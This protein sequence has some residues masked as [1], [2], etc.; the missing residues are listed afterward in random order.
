MKYIKSFNEAKSKTPNVKKI[1]KFLNRLGITEYTINP[2]GTVDL[3]N[4]IDLESTSDDFISFFKKLPI[5]FGHIEGDFTFEK[6]YELTTMEGFPK[7]CENFYFKSFSP[8]IKNL[9]G[10]P[11]HVSGHYTVSSYGEIT[12]LEGGPNYVGG[13]FDLSENPVTSLKGCPNQIEGDF[14]GD[15][16]R[17][18]SLE[19]CTQNIG[20]DLMLTQTLLTSLIGFPRTVTIVSISTQE[21]GLWDPTGIRDSECEMLY[22]EGEPL[23]ELIDLFNPIRD[24]YRYES[25]NYDQSIPIFRNFKDSL[26]YNY[27][28]QGTPRPQIDLFRLKEAL[29]E[30]DIKHTKPF[31][32][33]N[34]DF[35]NEK[36]EVVDFAGDPI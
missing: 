15:G 33:V 28:R 11:T 25:L 21:G 36:G 31:R 35:V 4:D 23:A 16:F 14:S 2:D 1:E 30:F 8:K 22:C 27:L 32:L 20:G 24:K 10:G 6:G 34:Y 9:K 19:G 5:K 18:T 13:S 3:G 12:S 29:E 17:I 26:D 7:S